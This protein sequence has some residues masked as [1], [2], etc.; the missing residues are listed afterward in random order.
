MLPLFH[1][2]CCLLFIVIVHAKK[3]FLYIILALETAKCKHF[4]EFNPV[5]YANK[6][7]LY[8]ITFTL[9]GTYW[10]ASGF[11][12]KLTRCVLKTLISAAG[13]HPARAFRVIDAIF[14]NNLQRYRLQ[15]NYIFREK[16]V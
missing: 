9:D 12:R 15:L 7:Q 13:G 1:Y 4:T 2:I 5:L 14:K 6:K 8:F 10:I 11:S 16:N 3:A